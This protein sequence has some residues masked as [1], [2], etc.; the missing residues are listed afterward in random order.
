MS[1]GARSDRGY[2]MIIVVLAAIALGYAWASR[3]ARRA[4]WARPIEPLS[5]PRPRQPANVR[6]VP[7]VTPKALDSEPDEWSALDDRQ[8]YRL[9]DE[10]GS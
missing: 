4:R 3:T 10:S 8:L 7:V 5:P 2:P 1:S 6:P 9:L